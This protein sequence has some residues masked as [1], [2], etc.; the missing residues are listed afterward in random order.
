VPDVDTA[1]DLDQ[2][3][4]SLLIDKKEELRRLELA[5]RRFLQLRLVTAGFL[6][7]GIT[8]PPICVVMEG[9]D[10][11]GKGGAIKRLLAPLDVRHYRVA[12]FAKPTSIEKAHTFLWRFYP[13][14][15]G[16]GELTVFD[17]S[18]YGRVLV[19]RVEGFA[20]EEEWGRAYQEIVD[21]ERSLTVEGAIV[22]KFW[23]HISHEEQGRR[24]ESRL[25]D[26]LRSWKL[27]AEDWRNRDKRPQ[28]EAAVRDMLTR[29]HTETAP[30]DVIEAESKRYARV[31]VIESVIARVEE[32]MR[33]AGVKPPP[34]LE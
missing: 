1:P 11:S 16:V 23:L 28:Y 18:W 2:V 33:R 30:W 8:G 27:D 4:L 3:D 19:E 26:P 14:L 34:P 21:F 7:D 25:A 17:R 29:T 24:F 20:T 31:R 6:G 13:S 22:I 10:A 9:W 15:P 12:C 32:G 5:Q